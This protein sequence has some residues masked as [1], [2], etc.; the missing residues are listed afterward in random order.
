MT[1]L[2]HFQNIITDDY[3]PIV[4]EV[5]GTDKDL[6]EISQRWKEWTKHES[7]NDYVSFRE[8]VTYFLERNYP[9]WADTIPDLVLKTC[10]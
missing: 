8:Y 4:I 3:A 9:R 1:K 2:V 10:F 6:N 5:E 7:R